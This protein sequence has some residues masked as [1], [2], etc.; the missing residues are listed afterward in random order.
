MMHDYTPGLA[1]AA[2]KRGKKIVFRVYSGGS[3]R[4]FPR[5]R[6]RSA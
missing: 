5:S 4:V 2:H 6:A 1:A 3:G